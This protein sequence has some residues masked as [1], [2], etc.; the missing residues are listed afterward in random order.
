M[1]SGSRSVANNFCFTDARTSTFAS[2]VY[3]MRNSL[4]LDHDG[5]VAHEGF[6]VTKARR[7][8]R[9]KGRNNAEDRLPEVEQRIPAG[10]WKADFI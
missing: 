3:R 2:L 9:M 5:L 7:R 10:D 1:N 6:I 8:E 4:L